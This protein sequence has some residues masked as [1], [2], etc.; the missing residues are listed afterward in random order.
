MND[1]FEYLRCYN[2]D[3][4]DSKFRV[5]SE[6]SNDNLFYSKISEVIATYSVIVNGVSYSFVGDGVTLIKDLLL[7]TLAT[8]PNIISY[9]LIFDP[10]TISPRYTNL[11]IVADCDVETIILQ[12]I[13]NNNTNQIPLACYQTGYCTTLNCLSETDFNT[14]VAKLMKECDICECQLN[15]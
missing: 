11:Y 7:T 4:K 10:A 3:A 1:W 15:Q 12:T 9:E 13:K 2:I 14:M 8:I 6:S 5:R